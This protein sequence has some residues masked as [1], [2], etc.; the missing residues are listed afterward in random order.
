MTLDSDARAIARAGIRAVDPWTAVRRALRPTPQGIEVG[1]ARLRP[2]PG[3]TVHLVAIGKA[4]AEM[5]DA[6]AALVGPAVQGFVATPKGYPTPRRAFRL[7]IGEHPVP[8]K[9]SFRAGG[10][11][12]DYVRETKREDLA[13]FLVSGGG[14]AVVEQ[15]LDPITEGDLTRTTEILLASGAP[16]GSVNAVRRHLSAIKGGR[17][18]LTARAR[19]FATIAISDVVGDPPADIASG[20]TVADPTRFRD[21]RFAARRYRID[22]KLPERV[23]RFLR[24]GERGQRPE[25]PK[26]GTARF[27]RAPCVLAATNALAL[28]GSAVEARRRGYLVRTL[29]DR[30]TGETAA[31]ARR[32]CRRLLAGRGD[33]AVRRAF[34]AGGE[35][36]VTLGLRHGKGGR[37]Q[38]FA[39]AAAVE[40]AGH[41]GTLVLS[42]GTD[43]IDGP[44]DAAGGWADDRTMVFAASRG[45][46]L[47]AALRRHDAYDALTTLGRLVKTGPTGTNVMDLHVGLVAPV[48][49][50]GYGR[51]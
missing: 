45:V 12:L 7:A 51:K 28:R 11:L 33:G 36:T 31:V 44:T 4:A 34:L 25:T 41:A 18:A 1:R 16:I 37:N 2:G 10:A 39:L 24:E 5:A 47:G 32:F 27:A 19:R 13:I 14:S 22:R 23:R 21:A 40:I 50:S 48:R 38:E 49:Q 43:G 26:P 15:P 42:L 29:S 20:P 17:L 8:R 6:A 46:D 35:T 3:G 30:L 9:G